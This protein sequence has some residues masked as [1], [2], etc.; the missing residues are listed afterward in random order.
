VR[1]VVAISVLLVA[2]LVGVVLV[3]GGSSASNVAAGDSVVDAGATAGPTA[4]SPVPPPEDA[5]AAAVAM[6]GDVVTAG[7]I[8]RRELIE[9]FTTPGFGAELA[10]LTSEQVTSMRLSLTEAGR[11]AIGLSVSEFPLRTNLVARTDDAATVAV[12]SVVVI[13]ANDA[14]VARQVWR[15]V[16]VDLVLVDGRWLVDGWTSVDGPTPAAAPEG[17]IASGTEVAGHLGWSAVG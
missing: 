17:Q 4:S 6:T 8:S 16:T 9:S 12:W 15:T 14:Q 10:D 2:G 5:A 1:R 13:A 7:L 11:S 3:R